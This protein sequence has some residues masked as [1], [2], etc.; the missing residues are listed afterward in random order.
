[1]L[2]KLRWFGRNWP[3]GMDTRRN[4]DVLAFISQGGYLLISVPCGHKFQLRGKS[5]FS[6]TCW[7]YI[8]NVC[9]T[10]MTYRYGV[11]KD[12][13]SQW[14]QSNLDLDTLSMENHG[15][16]QTTKSHSAMDVIT[17]MPPTVFQWPLQPPFL[18]PP[19]NLN[20]FL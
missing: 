7:C 18:I 16:I 10:N 15:F 4:L 11:L 12:G 5:L 13:S 8:T 3:G 9:Y 14:K 17:D 1:M 20:M 6:K 2:E 19:N